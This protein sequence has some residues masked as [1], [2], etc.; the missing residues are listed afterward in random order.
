MTHE[1]SKEQVMALT[2]DA[3][4]RITWAEDKRILTRN[5]DNP[6]IIAEIVMEQEIVSFCSKNGTV[7]FDI[8]DIDWEG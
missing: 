2:Q 7:S 3:L 5:E 4:E 6:Q 8:N 1:Q